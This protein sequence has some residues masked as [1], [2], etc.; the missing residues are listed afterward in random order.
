MNKS[1]LKS[2]IQISS[3]SFRWK[4]F[5]FN[6]SEISYI[7]WLREKTFEILS[8][9]ELQEEEKLSEIKKIIN[10]NKLIIDTLTKKSIIWDSTVKSHSKSQYKII[11][12]YWSLDHE[13]KDE[14]ISILKFLAIIHNIWELAVW[15]TLLEQKTKNWEN[16]EKVEAKKIIEK[17]YSWESVNF[18]E[19]YDIDGNQNHPLHKEFK[20]YEILSYINWAILTYK[21][22]EN[23]KN[24]ENIIKKVFEIH[25]P[26]V[27]CEISRWRKSFAKYIYDNLW[28]INEIATYIWYDITW[29]FIALSESSRIEDMEDDAK[30][31]LKYLK[32]NKELLISIF[33][34]LDWKEKPYHIFDNFMSKIKWINNDKIMIFWLTD[35]FTISILIH[36]NIL[37]RNQ[38]KWILLANMKSWWKWKRYIYVQAR[39]VLWMIEEWKIENQ[40][41]IIINEMKETYNLNKNQNVPSCPFY[42]SNNKNDFLENAIDYFLQEII[43]NI[44]NNKL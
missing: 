15:D 17:L 38:W 40:R 19:I 35:I 33:W 31:I 5:C 18:L 22:R 21:N 39:R 23:I 32:E 41:E 29:I 43:P 20:L 16:N 27:L 10:E 28:I 24:H 12:K 25:M 42:N 6:E 8:K 13:W 9:N 44:E 36:N 3:I 34:E 37:S 7:E 14:N 30:N 26:K 4:D 2:L 11:A 1:Y